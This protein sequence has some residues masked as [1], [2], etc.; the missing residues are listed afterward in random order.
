MPFEFKLPDIGEGVV[1][2][3]IIQWLIKEGETIDEDQA[4]VEVMTD[5]ATVEIPS[6]VAGKVISTFGKEGEIV[7]VGA[8]MVVIETGKETPTVHTVQTGHAPKATPPKRP[9]ERGK[10]TSSRVL[11]TPAIRRLAREK[12]VDLDLINGTGP[13]GRI[14]RKDV[15]SFT[16]VKSSDLPPPVSA[17]T[18]PTPSEQVAGESIPYR[19]LRKK[20]GDHLVA[21]KRFAPHFTYVEEVDVTQLVQLRTKYLEARPGARLTYLPFFIKAVTAGLKKFPLLNATLDE[22]KRLIHL[23]HEYNIGIATATDE[24]LIVPVVKNAD[25]LTLLE[26]AAEVTRLTEE[27]RKGSAKLED[28]RGGTF[29]LTSLGPL[30]GIVA[31]PIINYPEVGIL[32]IHKISQK[33]VVVDGEIVIRDRMNLSLSLDHRVVDGLVGAK[34]MH[35]IIPMIENPGLLALD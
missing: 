7:E 8:T 9:A 4:M 13:R 10:Q 20:I 35:S 19:G 34:F 30:G 21:A 17:R 1:E 16:A 28:L 5:K 25:R 32:G 3:E 15:E 2:G 14:T 18:E 27:A 12:K 33:P 26:L 23:K 11:A 29:T 22:E 24:G 31:T 6:P